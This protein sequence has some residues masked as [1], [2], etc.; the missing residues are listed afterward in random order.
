M[1]ETPHAEALEL[2]FYVNGT[3]D[4]SARARVEAHLAACPACRGDL[5]VVRRLQAM[6]RAEAEEAMAPRGGFEAVQGRLDAFEAGRAWWRAWLPGPRA[7]PAWVPAVGLLLLVVQ[8]AAL[9]TIGAWWVAGR[10]SVRALSGGAA[11]V[12]AAPRL[13]VIFHPEA[14]DGAIRAALGEVSGRI[15]D[16]PSTLGAY[17][18]AIDPAAGLDAEAAAA[19]L[20]EARSLVRFAEPVPRG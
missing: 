9:L 11:P 1:T 8:S 17:T 2:D 13:Q 12:S 3:L 18:V 7:V 6:V 5:A 14:T 15:V 4:A 20:R 10:P 16:G 19:H